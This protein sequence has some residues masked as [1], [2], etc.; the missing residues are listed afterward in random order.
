[1]NFTKKERLKLINQYKI[2][3]KLYPEDS[4]HYDE[5]REILEDGYEI[6]YSQISEWISQ[7]M[8]KDAGKFVLDVLDLY[9]AIEDYKRM[10]KDQETIDSRYSYFRGFDGNNEGQYMHFARFLI[11]K[12]NKFSEQKDYLRK[13]DNLNSHMPMVSTYKKMLSKWEEIGKPWNLNAQNINYILS[14]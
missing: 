6:F 8:P 11:H 3:S 14:I 7:D 10:S 13:N 9:R 2:L 12:Q 1:M 5:L 4:E